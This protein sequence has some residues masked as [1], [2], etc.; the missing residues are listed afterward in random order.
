VI[1]ASV[2]PLL[3]ALDLFKQ[4]GVDRIIGAGDIAGYGN[5]L[6]Q[7]VFLLKSNDVMMVSGNHDTWYLDKPENPMVENYLK[8]LPRFLDVEIENNRFYIVHASPPFSEMKGISLLDE[9]GVLAPHK[10]NFWIKE[11]T[12]FHA[13]ILMVGH[14]H[15]VFYEQLG[16][17]MI[18]NPGST[19][20]NH[21]C[22]I[23]ELPSRRIQ[24]FSLGGKK[25]LLAWNW[26]QYF[27]K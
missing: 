1:H 11:L 24:I 16:D 8:A 20:F 23:L 9:T 25:P 13:D 18:I 17:T 5:K 26:G 12:S 19:K 10:I 4:N 2:S 6:E 27:K 7:T 14:T 3:E 21:T 22:M 15:Q